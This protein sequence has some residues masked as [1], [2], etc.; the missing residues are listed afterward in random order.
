MGKFDHIPELLGSDNFPSWRRAVELVLA[1]EGLWNHC[2]SSTDPLD[3]AEF[4]STI[5]VPVVPATPTAAETASMREWIKEDAQTKAIIGRRLSPI[6]QNMLG[7]KLM[8]HQQWELFSK[9]LKD[10]DHAARYLGVFKN[11]RCRFAEMGISMIEE[12]AIFMFLH[13]LPDTPQW[14]VFCSLTMNASYKIIPSSTTTPATSPRLTFEEVTTSFTEEANHQTGKLKLQARPGSEYANAAANFSQRSNEQ[15]NDQR[16]VNQATGVQI[17][18]H[19]PKGVPCKNPV[20]NGLPRSLTHDQDHCLQPGGGMEGKAPWNQCGERRG[21]KKKD[22][23]AA[24]TEP[25]AP[26]T[27]ASTSTPMETA[28]LA[29]SNTHHQDWSCAT[30]QEIESITA[31]MP[32]T[33]NMACIASQT[34]STIL[35]SGT[36]STLIMDRKFFWTYNT[37]T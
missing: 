33:V 8:A 3:V 22:V 36:T 30:I 27:P 11:G 14:V 18:R 10:A 6:V 2:S 1:G 34:L 17:H 12:E 9:R 13:R 28:S 21:G 35:D 29:I 5:P 16:V 20:C 37:N 19:N 31:S 7:E 26:P 15:C 24:A 32:Q 25:K 23:S 4:A